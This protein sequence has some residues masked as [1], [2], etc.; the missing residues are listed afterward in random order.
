MKNVCTKYLSSLEERK[1][2]KI[3]FFNHNKNVAISIHIEIKFCLIS[4]GQLKSKN[5]Q[6][7]VVNQYNS[8]DGFY[9]TKSCA[10]IY[11]VI[12]VIMMIL[13]ALLT[14]ILIVPR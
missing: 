12:F 2:K 8:A 5:G 14:Y 6:K 10:F 13:T 3:N 1:K 7:Y 9:I 11:F 4:G